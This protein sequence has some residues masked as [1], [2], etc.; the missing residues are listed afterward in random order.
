MN[1]S[2]I[3][4][5]SDIREKTRNVFFVLLGVAV[6]L[7]KRSYVGPLQEIV[8]AYAGN[9]SISFALYFVFS[10]LQVPLRFK[11]FVAASLA[12][13]AVE[14]F[15]AF[16]G[17]GIT[18]NTYDPID[19]LANAVGIAVAFGLDTLLGA[20]RKHNVRTGPS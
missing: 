11:R 7:S 18:A 16:D 13:M 2:P 14:L 15:E 20:R 4:S 8:Y 17:F 5:R 10:K 12:L 1:A 19:F 6:L 9:L 3:A